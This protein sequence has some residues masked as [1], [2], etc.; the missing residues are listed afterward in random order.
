[1]KEQDRVLLW[2]AGFRFFLLSLLLI[3]SMT[4]ILISPV[5]FILLLVVTYMSHVCLFAERG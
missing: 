1:M 2:Y 5:R 3:P 4:S